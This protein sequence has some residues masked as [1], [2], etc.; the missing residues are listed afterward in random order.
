MGNTLV[1]E[2]PNGQIFA[3]FNLLANDNKV[4]EFDP[5]IL[6]DAEPL[7]NSIGLPYIGVS[8]NPLSNIKYVAELIEVDI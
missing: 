3:T 1:A 6:L 5:P 7:I 8:G 4:V 2:A